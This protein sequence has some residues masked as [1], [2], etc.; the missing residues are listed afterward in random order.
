MRHF[1]HLAPGPLEDLFEHPPEP[2]DASSPRDDLAVAMGAMLYVPAARPTLVKDLRAAR[3]AGIAAVAIDLEDAVSHASADACLEHV[4]AELSSV[5]DDKDGLP[6][7]F[8][9]TR[10]ADQLGRLVASP[11]VRVVAGCIAPK[12]VPDKSACAWLD[13]RA[14]AEH[15]A[16]RPFWL[17]P[18][19]EHAAMV[20]LETRQG[21]LAGAREVLDPVRERVL[22][23]RIGGVDACG[24]F[25]VRRQQDV[26]AYEV[27]VLASFIADVVN[28]F[29]R[30]GDYA[31]SGPV[32]EYFP[33]RERLLRPQL[34]QSPFAER[35]S[36]PLREQIL[37]ASLDGLLR[38]ALLDIAN[39]LTGK[40]VIHPSHVP[41]VHALAPTTH[42]EHLDSRTLLGAAGKGGVLRSEYRNKM[43]EEGPHGLWAR[44]LERRSRIFGVLRPGLS[45][46][47][48][49]AALTADRARAS[50]PLARVVR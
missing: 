41:V 24:V 32:W 14:A 34:R 12:F 1:G 38:E 30:A 46:F 20:H 27:G 23:V 8:V 35:G 15:G 33:P 7:T 11:A 50:V 44:R 21:M 3:A 6:L 36:A 13:A 40:S 45:A 17:L 37:D 16:G 19:I 26:T 18:V 28:V 25:G 4:I 43:N 22:A 5:R 42:E 48:V 10:T 49:L 29:A 2:F 39:G 9:R 31:V 47:D